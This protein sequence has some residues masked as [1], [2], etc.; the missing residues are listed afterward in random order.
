MPHDV[1]CCLQAIDH[2]HGHG[3]AHTE[4]IVTEDQAVAAAFLAR[5]DAAC[6]FHNASTRFSDGFR[7]G[8]GAE[9]RS[10]VQSM[11][12]CC[13]FWGGVGGGWGSSLIPIQHLMPAGSEGRAHKL[14]LYVG[15]GC[16]ASCGLLPAGVLTGS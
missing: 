9:V 13:T 4:V 6:V 3:S 5:V 2:I 14:L 12:L 1:Q 16:S 11:S 8:L 7:F 10:A 15:G